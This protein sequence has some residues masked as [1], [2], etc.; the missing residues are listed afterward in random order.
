[1]VIGDNARTRS[2]IPVSKTFIEIWYSDTIP[3]EPGTP[4]RAEGGAHHDH[5]RP[6]A[7]SYFSFHGIG[8][9]FLIGA[10]SLVIGV[11]VMVITSRFLPRYFADG[12]AAPAQGEGSASK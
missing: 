4:R 5:S 2:S 12:T 7:S 1:M 10:G 8:G 11:I 9:I 6:A 3:S